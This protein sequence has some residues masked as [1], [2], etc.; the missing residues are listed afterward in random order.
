MNAVADAERAER[1]VLA[2]E[3]DQRDLH[4]ILPRQVVDRE[5]HAVHRDRAVRNRNLPHRIGHTHVVHP[6]VA[7]PLDSL[8]HRDPVYVPLDDVAAQPIRR[9]QRALQVHRAP[10][11][12]LAEQRAPLGRLHHVH[13]ESTRQCPFDGETGA[14]HRD[15]LALLDTLVGSTDGQR[16]SR[17]P[18]P[19]SRFPRRLGDA[20]YGAHDSGKHSRL[21]NTNNVSGPRARRSTG[22][23][24]GAAAR[25]C[26]G[27]PGKAGTAPSPSHTGACT[28]YSRSTR[29][30]ARS[31][32]PSAPPPSHRSDWIPASRTMRRPSRN[33]VG[34]NTRTPLRSSWVTLDGG[35]SSDDMTHVGTSRAVLTSC[36][37]RLSIARRSNTTRTGG[38]RGVTGPR[39]VSCGLSWSAV[40]PTTAIRPS[41]DVASLSATKGR[42]ACSR[43]N[44]NGAFNAAPASA[45]RPIATLTPRPRNT[46]APP[47]A[48]G[49]GSGTAATTRAT[50]AAR[51]AS[52]QG[53]VLPW[54]AHGSRFTTRVAPR[55]PAPAASSATTS[56]CGPPYSAWY[57]SARTLPPASTTAPTSGFGATRPQPRRARSRA[58]SIASRSE[59]EPDAEPSEDMSRLG[60]EIPERGRE[61]LILPGLEAQ[62]RHQFH[63]GE[64]EP[65]VHEQ[66]LPRVVRID[67]DGRHARRGRSIVEAD[68]RLARRIVV[69]PEPRR[70][71]HQH[72]L[73]AC[74]GAVV[75]RPEVH[76]ERELVT[77]EKRSAQGAV[78][79][80]RQR[81]VHP[82]HGD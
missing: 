50:P 6:C 27:T 13:R 2:R 56:A 33:V 51:I 74:H 66:D 79:K 23:Q 4:E 68:T 48:C 9:A 14:V 15:A 44:R 57:P 76:A 59:P 16:Q 37:P 52:A 28:Q 3:R 36:T 69:D 61:A 45:S 1:R 35:A 63:R 26:G 31:R 62:L 8:H 54:C 30:S 73:P 25:G 21:S 80:P 41:I 67:D 18:F 40:V 64:I 10:G 46:A 20:P 17:L 7:T 78:L 39:T 55:A 82:T 72:E 71:V 12:V 60:I 11:H 65:A 49:S 19:V 58:R 32:A 24:R 47:R 53:G 43:A 75:V 77:A 70:D 38:R 22:V 34:R 29:P 81:A 5:T 42:S